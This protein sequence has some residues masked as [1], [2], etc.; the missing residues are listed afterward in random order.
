LKKGKMATGSAARASLFPQSRL[1]SGY[2]KLFL[3]SNPSASHAGHKSLQGFR[4]LAWARFAFTRLHSGACHWAVRAGIEISSLSRGRVTCSCPRHDDNGF[5]SILAIID[6]LIWHL[7]VV[8]WRDLRW[9]AGHMAHHPNGLH[10]LTLRLEG[11]WLLAPAFWNIQG[12]VGFPRRCQP[13]TS[14]IFKD[15]RAEA[16]FV[17]FAEEL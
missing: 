15:A 6:F 13:L 11:C 4:K 16:K 17:S 7:D 14:T 1:I 3:A 2:P 5:A 12:A 9:L 8:I 10:S